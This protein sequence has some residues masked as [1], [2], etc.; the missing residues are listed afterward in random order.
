[1]LI[2]IPLSPCTQGERGRGEGVQHPG[3]RQTPPPSPL[4]RSGTKGEESGELHMSDGVQTI[5]HG[6][7]IM[8]FHDPAKPLGQCYDEDLELIVRAEELG[9]SEFWI[10]EH[11]TMKYEN[12]VM[13]E[14]F[15]ARAL[16]ETKH[17]R[18]GPAPVCLN[19]H[20]P[21]HVASRLAFLDHLS[22][23]RLNLCFGSGSVPTDQELYGAEPKNAA[24]MVDEATDMILKLWS[25]GP[26]YEVEG[27]FWK[28]SLKK[29]V[30]EE[31]GIGY[32]HK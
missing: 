20:H 21:A 7:F 13:P 11:H 14:I 16:G 15:I 24:A 19:Q 27:K 29:S 26:P 28:I 25:S 3:R 17:I 22:K 2:G 4:S 5:R 30:D 6:M 23:G 8:P 10:G 12:I 31:T 18:L 32:V 1:M 9:F